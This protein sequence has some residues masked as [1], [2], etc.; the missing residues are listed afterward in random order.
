M[1]GGEAF[2][3]DLIIGRVAGPRGVKGELKVAMRG[4]DSEWALG[5]KQVFLGDTRAS[6]SVTQARVYQGQLLLHLDGI[7]D[8][9]QAEMWRDA[10]V[11]VAARD[12]PS[13]AHGEYYSDQIL[14]LS[15]TTEEGEMLGHITEI[16]ATGANDV[17]VVRGEGG[18]LLLPAIGDVVRNVDLDKRLMTVRLLAGLR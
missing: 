13:L 8:R 11:G 5:L 10:L 3:R 2:D 17:Y 9:N 12:L 7:H 6:F 15:V 4:A 14:G 16:L 18:E 1:P